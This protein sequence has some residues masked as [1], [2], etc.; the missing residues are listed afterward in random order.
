[1]GQILWARVK[2]PIERVAAQRKQTVWPTPTN[3]KALLILAYNWDGV[4]VNHTVPRGQ[5]VNAAYYCSFL[6]DQLLAALRR[7]RRH[8][9]VT[10]P[11][12]LHDNATAHTAGIVSALLN[13]WGWEVL[14]HP[15]S[16]LPTSVPATMIS[17]RRWRCQ[18]AGSATVPVKTLSRLPSTLFAPS[19][20]WAVPT[21]SNDFRVAGDTLYTRVGTSRAYETWNHLGELFIHL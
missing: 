3:V 2:T 1:M 15:P 5:T 11:I 6:Q 19:I 17:S 12:V 18:C 9:M 8:H 13:R 7:K 10:P 21:G 16:I 20:D 4:I 14:Y